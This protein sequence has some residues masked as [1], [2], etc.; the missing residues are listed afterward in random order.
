MTV[1]GRTLEHLGVQMYKSRAGAIA[2]LVANAWDAGSPKVDIIV[3]TEDDYDQEKSEIIICDYGCGMSFESVQ[4]EY[5][6][7]GRNRRK[8]DGA[9]SNGRPLMGRKGIGKLAGFGIAEHVSVHTWTENSSIQFEMSLEKLKVPSGKTDRL[10]IPWNHVTPPANGHTSGTAVKLRRLRHKSSLDVGSLGLSL[11]RRFSRRVVGQM[12]IM[13]NGVPLPDPTP[14]LDMRIPDN[15][16]L[17]HVL[18]SGSVVRYWYGFAEDLI[19]LKEQRGFTIQVHG[20]TAQAPPFFFDVEATASGQH[21]TKYIVGA[22]E[23][24]FL[25]DGDDDET[26]LVSTDRQEIDWE[27]EASAELR[28]WGEALSRKALAD[29]ADFRGLK[30][31]NWVLAEPGL[32]ERMQRFDP[33]TQREVQRFLKILGTATEKNERTLELAS[34]LV[35]A[36]EFHNFHNFIDDI[37][38]VADNPEELAKLLGYLHDWQVLESRAILEVIKGRLEIIDKFSSML[39]N[40]APETASK[41]SPCNMHDLLAG[42]PWLLNPEWQIL[43]EETT[44]TRQLR[45]WNVEDVPDESDRS[46]YDFLALSSESQLVVIEIKRPDLAASLDELQR[47]ETYADKLSIA[48]RDKTLFKV[49]VCGRDPKINKDTLRNWETRSDGEIRYWGQLFGRTQRIY[50]HYRAVLDRAVTHKDFAGA[51]AEV[52][53]A[54]RLLDTGTIHRDAEQRKLGIPHQD[55]DYL[56]SEE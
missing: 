51:Q 25:D 14:P 50:E 48:H 18:D 26:D 7:V 5:L 56:Q 53:S 27:D 17:E 10:N 11:A 33:P 21:S 6:V 12:E 19:A 20:K 8:E 28:D 38:A 4:G 24:D 34:S 39:V 16:M 1:L 55:V 22:I 42:H 46:R 40:D 32:N 31:E 44:I 52:S 9:E 45:E 54:K 15:G 23:A 47:L 36:Y 37:E 35:G 13:I 29:C 30:V 3:P 2:E 43:S 41:I 49:F